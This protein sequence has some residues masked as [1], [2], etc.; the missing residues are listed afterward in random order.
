MNSS[1]ESP[2]KEYPTGTDLGQYDS[3]DVIAVTLEDGTTIQAEVDE[4]HNIAGEDVALYFVDEDKG[5][6]REDNRVYDDNRVVMM[7][8]PTL[9]DNAYHRVTD[10]QRV[11]SNIDFEKFDSKVTIRQEATKVEPVE[12]ESENVFFETQGNIVHEKV[13]GNSLINIDGFF[14]PDYLYDYKDT[15]ET[16][17]VVYHINHTST[18]FDF[19][20]YADELLKAAEVRAAEDHTHAVRVLAHWLHCSDAEHVDTEDRWPFYTA[21]KNTIEE[22]GDETPQ[23]AICYEGNPENWGYDESPVNTLEDVRNYYL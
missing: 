4:R 5:R 17:G 9:G 3:G 6:I 12:S 1:T 13:L 2:N 15:Y 19:E 23:W 8:G 14:D 21:L 20:L 11:S 16:D 18:T 10:I 22:Y 7:A